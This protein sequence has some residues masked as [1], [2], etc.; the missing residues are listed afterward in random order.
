MSI[1]HKNWLVGS[2]LV[3]L[4][5]G[6]GFLAAALGADH[7]VWEAVAAVGALILMG[8]FVAA[9]EHP[10]SITRREW[11]GFGYLFLLGAVWVIFGFEYKRS[12]VHVENCTGK[13]L[14]VERN[15][16]PWLAVPPGGSIRTRLSRQTHHVVVRS[17]DGTQ[18][19][20]TSVTVGSANAYVLNLLGAGT[21]RR[22]TVDYHRFPVFHFGSAGQS[23]Y[24]PAPF[25]NVR[26]IVADVD[27][28]LEEPPSSISVKSTSSATRSYLVRV[29]SP[30]AAAPS[31]W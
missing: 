3:T 30:P 12:P 20:A 11:K 7:V 17:E 10:D 15:G 9:T 5:I 29:P 1:R 6:L 19:D 27:Y 25:S 31:S 13:T 21:Y 18:L 16:R 14:V 8:C 4:P 28:V 2:L 26:W 24:T 23:D 22:G